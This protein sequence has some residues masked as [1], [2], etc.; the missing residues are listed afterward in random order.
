MK[1]T[2]IQE[3]NGWKLGHIYFRL[4]HL[5][6][7]V[8]NKREFWY[9]MSYDGMRTGFTVS[10][11]FKSPK[12]VFNKLSSGAALY[13]GP[14]RRV[15]H[16]VA[17]DNNPLPK[18][19]SQENRP[20]SFSRCCDASTL[21]L[22]QQVGY[23]HHWTSKE[24]T[25]S[26]NACKAH[27]SYCLPSLDMMLTRFPRRYDGFWDRLKILR[28][29]CIWG[30]KCYIRIIQVSLNPIL[31]SMYSRGERMIPNTYTIHR[32]QVFGTKSPYYV[33]RVMFHRI[34]FILRHIVRNNCLVCVSW[35]LLHIE[36]HL[37]ILVESAQW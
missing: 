2:M 37:V 11:S 33:S 19:I 28:M 18:F 9:L 10:E 16:D 3:R 30:C 25:V 23:S 20:V 12:K 26:C 14:V 27:Q 29:S 8:E 5:T 21:Q 15:N 1:L 31:S 4:R 35:W 22:C 13:L 24:S 7:V 32:S 6:W 17:E 36:H 34:N